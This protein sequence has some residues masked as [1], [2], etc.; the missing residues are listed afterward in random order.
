[1]M[2]RRLSYITPLW[3]AYRGVFASCRESTHVR[4][5]I[6][7]EWTKN[8]DAIGRMAGKCMYQFFFAWLAA[9][10]ASMS[11]ADLSILQLRCV[12][13]CLSA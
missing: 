12:Y 2:A 5:I 9:R 13:D 4:V 10:L 11:A 3:C 7:E 6:L 1:M 8:M